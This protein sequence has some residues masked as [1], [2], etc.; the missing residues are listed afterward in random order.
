MRIGFDS[1]RF[2]HNQTGLGNYSREVIYSLCENNS[3]KEILLF[4]SKGNNEVDY[5]CGQLIKPKISSPIWRTIGLGRS[6]AKN[7]I[8]IFH[9]LSNEFPLDLPSNIP[10]VCTIHDVIFRQF[11][12]QY[13][14]I[15]RY[16]YHKKTS[17]A[18]LH[19][20]IIIV[21]S[22]Y[23]RKSI[24]NFYSVDNSKIK[25]IYQS[26]N[27]EFAKHQWQPNWEQP[28]FVYHSSFNQRKNHDNLIRAFANLKE[29]T[30][31]LVLIGEG[32][33]KKN[34]IRDIEKLGLSN[35]VEIFGHL[36]LPE[37][38]TKLKHSIGFVYPSIFEGFGI[39]LTEVA[40][41][42]IPIIASDID[43]FKELLGDEI[44]Y[45]DPHNIDSITQSMNQLIDKSF[46]NPIYKSEILKEVTRE[47]HARN[48]LEIYQA[49]KDI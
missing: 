48:L 39:P 18:L 17:G 42:G 37:L 32:S 23:T 5:Q 30:I 44:T 21:P 24:L 11:P 34:L 46:P 35:H 40:T 14:P 6:V 10:S 9:G 31:K 2:F 4:D 20:D 15:D 29:D 8:D 19:S 12:Q 45:F 16:I 22:E 28:Y 3:N 41:M 38:I 7:K 26:I 27:P 25:V 47:V 33:E 13:K 43:V 1:K 36:N 49:I